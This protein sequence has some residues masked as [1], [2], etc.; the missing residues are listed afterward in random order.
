MRKVWFGALVV[1]LTFAFAN[2]CSAQ[3]FGSRESD[4]TVVKK[5]KKQ[6]H[7]VTLAADTLP[8]VY[9]HAERGDPSA[10]DTMSTAH[11]KRK[12]EKAPRVDTVSVF[13]ESTYTVVKH[14]EDSVVIE[15]PKRQSKR[16]KK[17]EADT[18]SDNAN[19]LTVPLAP[20][21]I[22][23]LLLDSGN[24]RLNRND[25]AGS[26]VFFDSLINHY[27]G[28]FQHRLAYY[29]RG[30]AKMAMNN[31]VPAMVDFNL[32]NQLDKCQSNFCTD[33]HYNLAV[34]KFRNDRT[35]ECLGELKYVFNDSTYK[36]YKYAFFY[37]GFCNGKKNEYAPA[38]QD[39]TRFVELDGGR[40]FSS[41][42]ALYYRGFYKSELDD[43]R[44]AIK[45]YDEAIK[46]YEAGAGK[47]NAYQQ[48]LIDTYIVRALC[49]AKIKK[50][51]EA[52]ADYD[53]VIRLNP[54]YGTAYRLKG[55]SEIGKGD[56]DNGCLDLSRAGELGSN[57]AYDD[58]KQH[59]R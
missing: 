14:P 38:V 13:N 43:N 31:D 45:D 58:I 27:P 32:F 37:R 46:L 29:F 15:K 39:L 42:E 30:K 4:S 41:A 11:K 33:A 52:I 21:Q 5:E 34:L 28:T 20:E 47:S 25:Y 54:K 59:C 56:K 1:A 49:K 44:G 2:S 36:N 24:F 22:A 40:T 7:R 48:K 51:D 17:A 10:K 23:S 8:S 53:V 6:R 50:F 26:I 55:L 16:G 18:T 57:E 35:D 19:V 9:D 3:L 12:K